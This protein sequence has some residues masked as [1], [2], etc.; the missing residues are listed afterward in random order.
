M[1]QIL[2]LIRGPGGPGGQGPQGGGHIGPRGPQ[3][4]GPQGGGPH[5]TNFGPQGLTHE[6]ARLGSTTGTHGLQVGGQAGAQ[7]GS[8]TQT[9]RQTDDRMAV[10]HSGSQGRLGSLEKKNTSMVRQEECV[11]GEG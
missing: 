3:G 1:R 8:G 7:T 9:G 10:V 11:S 2:V 5:E 4:G 6:G